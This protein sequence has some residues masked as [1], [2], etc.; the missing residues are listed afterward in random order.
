MTLPKSEPAGLPISLSELNAEIADWN[1][2]TSS[3]RPSTTQIS[4]ND[5]E[6]RAI[7]GI[8]SGEI[9]LSDFY[10]QPKAISSFTRATGYG[11][12]GIL[13][14]VTYG[15]G[16]WV[17]VGA[18]GKIY[19]STNRTT[20]TERTSNTTQSITGVAWAA[21]L[22]LFAAVGNNGYIA[23]SADGTTWTTRTAPSVT[24]LRAGL[25]TNGST[26]LASYATTNVAYFLRSSNGTT[27]TISSPYGGL[28]T[29]APH[30]NGTLGRYISGCEDR[31]IYAI[32]PTT[33][34]ISQLRGFVSQSDNLNYGVWHS[35]TNPGSYLVGSVD[36][37]G[38]VV[39]VTSLTANSDVGYNFS[40]IVGGLHGTPVRGIQ[41]SEILYIG[42][43][44]AVYRSLNGT[45]IASYTPVTTN[46]LYAGY[47]DGY[48]YV[49]VGDAGTILYS[50]H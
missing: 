10:D 45:T 25:A 12:T 48:K 28:D 9:G 49:L 14:D 36:Y 17:T 19:T 20:W 43:S 27:W 33:F 39:R 4:L 29:S 41:G 7:A 26:F 6:A 47:C 13:Y 31:G 38:N 21:N 3:T 40:P 22:G 44:G 24:G 18:G 23:T 30:W 34:V 11:G 5:T 8:Y 32:H 15:N 35:G 16:V 37:N 2:E 42:A 46:Y 1:L 50:N